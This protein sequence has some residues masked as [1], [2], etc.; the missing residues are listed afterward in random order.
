MIKREEQKEEIK[1][2]SSRSKRRAL[3]QDTYSSIASGPVSSLSLV[4][5]MAQRRAVHFPAVV[6]LI[7]PSASIMP[8]QSG[9]GGVMLHLYILRSPGGQTPLIR[10]TCRPVFVA[11][12]EVRRDS[13][14]LARGDWGDF[15]CLLW[16]VCHRGVR[17]PQS[18]SRRLGVLV[19]LAL[20]TAG[21]HRGPDSSCSIR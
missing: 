20:R 5:K 6:F 10:V 12:R 4:P 13:L 17:R 18:P 7:S 11:A 21:R 3:Q 14:C 2:K 16:C 9:R 8:P 19:C 1:W 15:S